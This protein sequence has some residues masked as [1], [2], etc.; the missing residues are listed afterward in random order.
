ME[1]EDE[2]SSYAKGT[3]DG[4]VS[5]ELVVPLICS[6]IATQPVLPSPEEMASHHQP[7][8][9][10]A[11]SDGD[12]YCSLKDALPLRRPQVLTC[13]RPAIGGIDTAIGN[14]FG[15]SDARDRVSSS[16]SVMRMAVSGHCLS[17]DPVLAT[18]SGEYMAPSSLTCS[19][20]ANN[21]PTLYDQTLL[22]RDC[23]DPRAKY[24]TE[25]QSGF[26]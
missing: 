21:S 9:T 22:S 24:K 15:G 11:S 1:D 4:C 5:V 14:V 19:L 3:Q 20:V 13:G 25:T 18:S 2:L 7:T 17:A 23:I 26:L 12:P 10:L 8:R 6:D 16:G